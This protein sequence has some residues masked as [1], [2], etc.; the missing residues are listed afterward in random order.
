MLHDDFCTYGVHFSSRGGRR[1][2]SRTPRRPL[3]LGAWPR[4]A[5]RASREPALAQLE[6]VRIRLAVA[7]AAQTHVASVLS[8]LNLRN[9]V[10]AVVLA[11]ETG[12]V[13]PGA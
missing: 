1:R 7:A 13:K 3:L 9:R 8:K 2:A 11:Y 12:R 6:H 10:Q 4:G 5:A